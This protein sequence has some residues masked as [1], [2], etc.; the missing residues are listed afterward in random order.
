MTSSKTRFRIEYQAECW[1]RR[2][3]KI[4]G[5]MNSQRRLYSASVTIEPT[6]FSAGTS[7]DSMK[8]FLVAINL[9]SGETGLDRHRWRSET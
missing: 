1:G 5:A 4:L 7:V 3:V 2:P 9:A 6:V 8:S